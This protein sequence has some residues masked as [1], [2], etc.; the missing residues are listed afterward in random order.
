[1]RPGTHVEPD[2]VIMSLANSELDRAHQSALGDYNEQTVELGSFDL[3]QQNERLDY[4]SRIDDIKA[5]LERARLE[6]DV[7]KQLLERG[8]SAKLEI[9]RAKLLVKK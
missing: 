8:V 4:Q 2:T 5:A 6:Q 7:N 9:Q 3:E 1:M